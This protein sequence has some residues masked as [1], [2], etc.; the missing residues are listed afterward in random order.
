MPSDNPTPERKTRGG[1][2]EAAKTY[3]QVEKVAQIAFVLPCAVLIGWLGGVWLDNHFHQSWMTIT[4]FLLGCVAGMTT[5]IRMAMALV[6][7][8][9]KNAGPHS[10]SS[11]PPT[12]DA[13]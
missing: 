9:K 12:G 13:Q 2:A 5:A 11:K 3:V 10:D 6:Q 7:E 4:G 8:P 1:L